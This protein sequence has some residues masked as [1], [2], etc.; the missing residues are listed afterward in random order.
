[1]QKHPDVLAEYDRR[2]AVDPDTC[3]YPYGAVSATAQEPNPQWCVK[4]IGHSGGH[5][6]AARE[7][8]ERARHA[9]NQAA[10][11]ERQKLKIKAAEEP[12]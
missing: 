1:M 10:Y 9:R 2:I 11:R 6:D 5:S 3:H 12:E 4:G 7:E 8:R